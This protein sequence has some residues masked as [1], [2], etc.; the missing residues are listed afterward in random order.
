MAASSG[1]TSLSQQRPK[2]TRLLNDGCVGKNRRVDGRATTLYGR[3]AERSAIQALLEAARASR[4]GALVIRGPAGVGK[5]ALL[6]DAIEWADGMLVLEARGIE[7][8]AELAFATLHQLLRPVLGRIDALPRLQARALRAALGL[9]QGS[10]D[11]RFLVSVA[12]LTLLAEAGGPLP[13]SCVLDD[14]QWL[15]E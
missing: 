14:A 15:D 13:V 6:R 7:S 12:V 8:E 11:D 2:E 1:E 10:I 5:S 9:E 3:E 4:S